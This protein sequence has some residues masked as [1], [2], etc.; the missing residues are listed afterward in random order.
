MNNL[1]GDVSI[2][3][4]RRNNFI[5]EAINSVGLGKLG[6]CVIYIKN[7][8]TYLSFLVGPAGLEPATP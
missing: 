6:E 3:I 8:K 7:I 4:A 2:R 5:N 1:W